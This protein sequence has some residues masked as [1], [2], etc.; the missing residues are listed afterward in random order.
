MGIRWCGRCS[1]A[2][3]IEWEP[4]FAFGPNA[5]SAR[6]PWCGAVWGVRE[7]RKGAYEQAVR[8]RM[9]ALR[10]E[11]RPSGAPPSR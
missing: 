11:S 4:D 2:R 3:E 8:Q 7:R 1:L 10:V 6:C 5:E 9:E